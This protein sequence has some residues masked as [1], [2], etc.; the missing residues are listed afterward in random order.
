MEAHIYIKDI[1][2]EVMKVVMKEP[3]SFLVP[4]AIDATCSLGGP[5]SGEAPATA[6]GIS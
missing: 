2:N 1:T 4:P 6:T 5:N 3:P